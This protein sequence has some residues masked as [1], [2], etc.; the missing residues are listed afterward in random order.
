[1]STLPLDQGE[2]ELG[3]FHRGLGCH[4]ST[5]WP[6]LCGRAKVMCSI[7]RIYGRFRYGFQREC[8]YGDFISTF[9]GT[10]D[11]AEP[12]QA[13]EAN[14]KRWRIGD[15]RAAVPAT[16]PCRS[17]AAAAGRC[18][19]LAAHHRQSRHGPAPA[20]QVDV[21]PG[22][23]QIRTGSRPHGQTGDAVDRRAGAGGATGRD[24]RQES[25]GQARGRFSSHAPAQQ[26]L[27]EIRVRL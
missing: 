19:A 27:C 14:D 21:G 7:T 10:Q 2:R 18:A 15:G 12:S 1:M 13:V 17:H 3:D 25:T 4:G 5:S 6:T 26:S 16:S 23:R 24:R 8:I 20:G 9:L 22:R 11:A